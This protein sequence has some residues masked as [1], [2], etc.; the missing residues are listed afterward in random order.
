MLDEEVLHPYN[1]SKNKA[2]TNNKNIFFQINLSEVYLSVA[3]TDKNI[4]IYI[5]IKVNDF[6]NTI[7]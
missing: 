7:I 1:E 2:V 3:S 6:K 5:I 4:I